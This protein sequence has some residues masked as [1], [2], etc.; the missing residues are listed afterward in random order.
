MAGP[1]GAP[2][3]VVLLVGPTGGWTEGEETDIRAAGF[4]AVSLGRRILKSE[5]AALAGAFLIVHHWNG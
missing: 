3:S 1:D 5:T 4:E 2:R